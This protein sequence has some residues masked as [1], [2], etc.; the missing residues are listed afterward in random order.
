ML[1][2]VCVGGVCAC[3][4]CVLLVVCTVCGPTHCAMATTSSKENT[5]GTTIPGVTT[6]VLD[7]E[8]APGFLY[9]LHREALEA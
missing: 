8:R 7:R 5:G 1:C 9:L 6:A 2:V 4:S 3:V